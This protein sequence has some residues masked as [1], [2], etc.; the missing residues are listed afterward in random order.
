M[1]RN[2]ANLTN[3]GEL[4]MEGDEE[5]GC[6]GGKIKTIKYI[7]QIPSTQHSKVLPYPFVFLMRKCLSPLLISMDLY[8]YLYM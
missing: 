4:P 3:A 5:M 2:N 8:K 1:K 7:Q 6:W